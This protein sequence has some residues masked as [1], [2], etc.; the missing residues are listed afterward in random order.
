M[1]QRGC[2]DGRMGSVREQRPWQS[3]G[4]GKGATGRVDRPANTLSFPEIRVKSYNV[5]LAMV[6]YEI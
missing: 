3:P 1:Q 2:V 6:T 5:G 4:C